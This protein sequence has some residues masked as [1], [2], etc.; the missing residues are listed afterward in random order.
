[1][2]ISEKASAQILF[3][4]KKLREAFP[5]DY[6]YRLSGKGCFA[7]SHNKDAIDNKRGK[8]GENIFFVAKA[9][10]WSIS[11]SADTTGLPENMLIDLGPYWLYGHMALDATLD[12]DGDKF[13]A[14][15]EPVEKIC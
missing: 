3:E 11:F 6:L 15:G 4:I 2:D 8:N 14:N 12:Y 1:M 10:H 7:F 9:A 13:I 5:E